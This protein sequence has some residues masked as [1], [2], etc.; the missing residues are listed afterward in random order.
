MDLLEKM[1]DLDPATR[2]DV[3]A[4][5]SHPYMAQYHDPADE[6]TAQPFDHSFE[7]QTLDVQGW[8]SMC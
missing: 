5:I 1:L 2:I 6:P 4:A 8:K 3:E 7:T